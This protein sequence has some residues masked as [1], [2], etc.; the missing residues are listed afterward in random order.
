MDIWHKYDM[1]EL[2][3][4]KSLTSRIWGHNDITIQSR[5]YRYTQYTTKPQKVGYKDIT[6]LLYMYARDMRLSITIYNILQI[7]G[8]KSWYRYRYQYRP[9]TFSINIGNI[10]KYQPYRYQPILQG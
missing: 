9:M 3:C 1:T 2:G 7:H 4:N 5:V 10:F 6:A 8:L